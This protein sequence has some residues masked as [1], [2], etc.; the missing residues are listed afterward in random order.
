M[1]IISWNIT[2]VGR[3][4]KQGKVRQIL[5][6]RKVDVALF[7]E[8]KKASLTEKEVRSMRAR[9]K[10]D[11]M[12]VDSIGLSGGLLCIWDPEVFQLQACCSSRRFILLSGEQ[13]KDQH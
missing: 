4:Q 5:K 1:K 11:F 3:Q 12:A 7:Q 6:E 10:M 2:G 9:D 8:T 13:L